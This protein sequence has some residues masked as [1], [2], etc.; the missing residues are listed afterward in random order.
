M[1]MHATRK[2]NP[3]GQ[4]T[5]KGA[6]ATGLLTVGWF[7][8][9]SL[10]P[11]SPAIAQERRQE[12]LTYGQF[13]EKIE[14]GQVDQVDLDE[15]RGL[16]Y[17]R[18]EGQPE[19]APPQRVTL[20]TGERNAELIRL[21]RD[22]DVD[23]EIADSSGNSAL[24]WLATNSLLALILIF[25]LLMIL[26]RSAS[27]AGN[28]MNFGRSKARFQMEAK[29]GVVFDDVAGVEEAKEELQEVVSFLKNP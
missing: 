28:A 4:R 27:G 10:L 13:L 23:V 6:T 1:K 7:L 19:D 22:N 26:R 20:F 5:V 3:T 24:A 14:Q 29:T 21:L 8:L 25:G 12:E 2:L 11:L 9:Q 17:V 18:L 16:A 15:T